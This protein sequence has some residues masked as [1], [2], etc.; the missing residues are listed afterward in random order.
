MAIDLNDA[1]LRED[2]L[3]IQSC[4]LGSTPSVLADE[5]KPGDGAEMEVVGE[6]ISCIGGVPELVLLFQLGES[7]CRICLPHFLLSHRLQKGL[8]VELLYL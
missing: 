2:A 8:E 7:L 6:A 1:P 3:L 4:Y 5:G